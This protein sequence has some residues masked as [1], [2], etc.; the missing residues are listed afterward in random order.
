MNAWMLPLIAI[1]YSGVASAQI[2]MSDAN[3]RNA[4]NSKAAPLLASQLCIYHIEQKTKISSSLRLSRESWQKFQSLKSTYLSGF[5][6]EAY[7]GHYQDL[8]DELGHGVGIFDSVAFHSIKTTALPRFFT[9]HD[10]EIFLGDA[11][12][13]RIINSPEFKSEI[14]NCASIFSED[15]YTLY[16]KISSWV[17]AANRAGFFTGAALQMAPF[18][19]AYRAAIAVISKTHWSIKAGLGGSAAL[20]ISYLTY[21][22]VKTVTDGLSFVENEI[23]SVDFTDPNN[24]KNLYNSSLRMA[25][26]YRALLE[27]EVYSEEKLLE[28]EEL[29]SYLMSRSDQVQFLIALYENLD[30]ATPQQENQLRLLRFVDALLE[31]K[32]SD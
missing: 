31:A 16:G 10:R 8:I 29:Q 27:G 22:S 18:I 17:E 15:K 2:N 13:R 23:L 11:N 7:D 5:D 32:E 20:T 4:L 19:V 24:W 21:D 30:E 6:Y 28:I 12:L 3:E 9:S 1:F 25:R 14:F 26:Y